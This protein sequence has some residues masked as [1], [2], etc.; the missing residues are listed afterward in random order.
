VLAAGLARAQPSELTAEIRLIPCGDRTC[1][2][3]PM[4]PQ[5]AE[6]DWPAIL[7]I[8]T[9]AAASQEP[10]GPTLFGSHSPDG[11]DLVFHPRLP[12]LPGTPYRATLVT[13]GSGS[14]VELTFELPAVDRE[15]P[16]VVAIR[17]ASPT[18][19]ANLLRAYVE[20]SQPMRPD[21]VADHLRLVDESG[22]EVDLPFVEIDGG[23]WDP[24]GTRLTLI[25]HPGRIKR[26]VAPREA[27]GPP[28]EE[29]RR[30]RLEIDEDWPAAA[31][32]PL[33]EGARHDWTVTREDRDRV[34]PSAWALDG[35]RVG[36]AQPLAVEFGEPLDHALALRLLELWVDDEPVRGEARLSPEADRWTFYPELPWSD[37][38]HTLRIHPSLEDLAGN[39]LR[40]L[41]DRPEDEAETDRG[42]T[43][44]VFRPL[45]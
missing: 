23:L 25:F 27:M 41:F 14:A 20:F 9:E 30:Y 24:S 1:V 5:T 26:G 28:L 42:P 21:V 35:P 34:T 2:A 7:Q 43:S 8:R 16:R 6:D 3:T 22:G 37:A 39:S 33:A 29:G 4:P 13:P 36:T 32:T 38:E 10:P 15:P 44:I 40:G 11:P 19:P 18:V 17:P 45:P 31:G 12:L